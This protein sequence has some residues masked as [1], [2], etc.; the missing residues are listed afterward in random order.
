MKKTKDV[1]GANLKRLR[2][3][4]GWTQA[5]LAEKARLS[6]KMIQKIEY[7]ATSP[8]T[9]TLDAI[10]GALGQPIARFFET[11]EFKTKAKATTAPGTG[12]RIRHH[13]LFEARPDDPEINLT[14]IG[15]ENVLA[16][17]DLVRRFG[18]ASADRQS[19][20]MAVLYDE[21]LLPLSAEG[22]ALLRRLA[23][24]HKPDQKEKKRTS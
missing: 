10:A 20:V 3:Q 6:V 11:D 1:L 16:A 4:R 21:P 5:E 13:G 8:S 22:N 18:A 23:E 14:S 19:I 9:T 12:R 17:F 7:G 24:T 15:E 2:D